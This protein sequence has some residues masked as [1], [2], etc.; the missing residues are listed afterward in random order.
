MSARRVYPRGYF[1]TIE[2]AVI[3]LIG[4]KK[5]IKHIAKMFNINK[6]TLASMMSLAKVSAIRIRHEQDK[7]GL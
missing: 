1:K 4:K 7:A 2:P 6:N 3:R 5:S